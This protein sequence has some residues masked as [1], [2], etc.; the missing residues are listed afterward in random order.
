GVDVLVAFV[1]ILRV[2]HVPLRRHTHPVEKLR[3]FC[4]ETCLANRGHRII[5]L[6]FKRAVSVDT[7]VA[8]TE[9]ITNLDIG[10]ELSRLRRAGTRAHLAAMRNSL[11][12]HFAPSATIRFRIDG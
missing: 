5:R 6:M 12:G 2:T 3:E 7:G 10:H 8:P 1:E 11:H 4:A 9:S